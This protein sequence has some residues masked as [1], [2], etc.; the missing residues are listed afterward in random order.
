MGSRDTCLLLHKEVSWLSRRNVLTRLVELHNEVTIYS[1]D[2]TEY[3]KHL[4]D[5]E[6]ILKL[7]YLADVFP[8]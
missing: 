6:F 4:L 3:I 8:N 1:E 2:K 5:D 7:T